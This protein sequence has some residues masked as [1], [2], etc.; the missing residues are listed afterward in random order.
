VLSTLTVTSPLD[1]GSVGTLRSQIA[2]ASSGDTID[3]DSNLAGATITLNSTFGELLIDKSL[4]IVDNDVPQVAVSGGGSRVFDIEGSGNTVTLAGLVIENG[5]AT[6]GGGILIGPGVN[7]TVTNS[8]ITHNTATAS[9]DPDF[10]FASGG[11][12]DNSGILTI[13]NSTLSYNTATAF[14]GSQFNQAQGGG[15]IDE[16]GGALT[17]TNSTLSNNKATA[18]SGMFGSFALGGGIWSDFGSTFTIVSSTLSKNQATASGQFGSADGGGI[19]N[20][21]TGDIANSSLTGNQANSDFTSGS[22][23]VGGGIA[24]SQTLTIE[25]STLSNN[26]ATGF[27]A[28]GGGIS[29]DFRSTL[30]ITKASSFIGNQAIGDPTGVGEGGA[31]HIAGGNVIISPSTRFRNN[32]ASTGFP[33]VFGHYSTH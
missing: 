19:F 6:S 12:I 23:S 14:G 18:S 9:S 2:A 28:Y 32:F 20:S 3:F 26:K 4:N 25:N 16:F 1:D 31:I 13:T 15:I 11:G 5:S 10:N 22:L 29:N 24:N 33:D 7:V 8:T 27:D 17:I 21:G 30:I